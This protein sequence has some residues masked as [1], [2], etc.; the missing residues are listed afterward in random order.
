MVPDTIL[1]SDMSISD[2]IRALDATGR[3]R[4]EIARLLGKRY[5][6]VRNVLEGDKARRAPMKP[7]SSSRPVPGTGRLEVGAGGAV[8]IPAEIVAALG[9][10]AGDAVVAQVQD[11]RVVLMTTTVALRQARA[12][13]RSIVPE[14]VSLSDEL[15]EDRRREARREAGRG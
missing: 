2:K 8:L 11:D 5:Q 15:I 3:P 6:H 9:V 4:A 12:L 10:R 1:N 14:G 13:V 7:D